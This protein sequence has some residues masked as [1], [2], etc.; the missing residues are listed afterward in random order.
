MRRILILVA[1]AL[2]VLPGCAGFP[3]IKIAPNRCL[4]YE[5]S[6]APEKGIPAVDLCVC[7]EDIFP[8]VEA[9]IQTFVSR[10]D[11]ITLKAI[12]DKSVCKP[13]PE[14]VPGNEDVKELLTQ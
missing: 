3:Q 1:I 10:P 9:A 7:Q 2:I 11:V 4:L 14:P 13:K 12:D 6:W 8:A 5:N